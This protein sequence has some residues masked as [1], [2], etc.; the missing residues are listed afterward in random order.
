MACVPLHSFE[1]HP[2]RLCRLDRFLK[3]RGDINFRTR[4]SLFECQ[5][6]YCKRSFAENLFLLLSRGFFFSLAF[7]SNHLLNKRTE[8]LDCSV[9]FENHIVNMLSIASAF[10]AMS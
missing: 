6:R 10:Q 3:Y 1:K 9:E 5:E 8:V 2:P 7:L 4:V